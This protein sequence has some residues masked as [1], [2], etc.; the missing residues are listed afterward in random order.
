MWLFDRANHIRLRNEADGRSRSDWTCHEMWERDGSAIIY[1]GTLSNG[2][3]YIG[4]VNPDGTGVREIALPA[5]YKRYGHF[6]VGGPNMLVSDGCYEEDGDRPAKNWATGIARWF[7]LCRSLSS[8]KSQD[9]HPHPIF[10]HALRHAYFTSDM[11]GKRA[12]YRIA[13]NHPRSTGAVV[14]GLRT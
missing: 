8:W 5:S 1:H 14:T 10:D 6:T 3:L 2:H 11:D 13:V 12:V 9:E 7:P 4:R